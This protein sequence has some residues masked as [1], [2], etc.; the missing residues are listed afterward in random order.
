ML[1]PRLLLHLQRQNLF[2]LCQY[3]TPHTLEHISI[4]TQCNQPFRFINPTYRDL[5]LSDIYKSTKQH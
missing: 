5:E 3:E 2:S 1:Q 4:T